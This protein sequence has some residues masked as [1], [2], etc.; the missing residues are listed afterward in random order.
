MGLKNSQLNNGITQL[1]NGITNT[2]ITIKNNE[3]EEEDKKNKNNAYKTLKMKN[4]SRKT[5]NTCVDNSIQ[6]EN[7]HHFPKEIGMLK[8]SNSGK[9]VSDV[10]FTFGNRKKRLIMSVSYFLVF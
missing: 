1:N 5:D 10:R 8:L 3:N 6:E 9:N 4:G 2:F 7:F